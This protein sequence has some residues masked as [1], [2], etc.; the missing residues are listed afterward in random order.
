MKR[1]LFRALAAATIA[2]AVRP[3][4]A[5]D[6]RATIADLDA[7]LAKI[8]VPRVDGTDTA[9]DKTVPALF[10]GDRKINN[11][12]DVVDG[13]RKAH[14]ANATVFVRQGDEF[15]RVSTNV[16]TP[17]GK[18]GVGTVLARNAA[19]EAVSAG[20]QYCGPI[21]VLGRQFDACYNPIRDGSG[22]I[23]GVSYIGHK[24]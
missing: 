10:F 6:P 9:G 12:Y 4:W 17:E 22:K 5:N 19:Y 1:T 13:I 11:N 8:G 24:R 2:A 14:G 7:R 23:I 3:A 20:K 15:V 18:R 16:L 21:D